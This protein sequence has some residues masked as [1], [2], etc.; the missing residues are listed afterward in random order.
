MLTRDVAGHGQALA[1]LVLE[2]GR[3][4]VQ[5]QEEK[6]LWAQ[7]ARESVRLCQE[8]SGLQLPAASSLLSSS[9]QSYPDTPPSPTNPASL[10]SCP[11]SFLPT[12][13]GAALL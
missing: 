7:E 4:G 5:P 2:G 6:G 9:V 3:D 10:P 13:F 11:V 8:Q 12:T 1:M